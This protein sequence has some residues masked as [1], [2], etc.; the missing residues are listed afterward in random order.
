MNCNRGNF[1][2]PR[3]KLEMA[4]FGSSTTF[5]IDMQFIY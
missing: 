5:K 4:F 1:I 2:S 3:K